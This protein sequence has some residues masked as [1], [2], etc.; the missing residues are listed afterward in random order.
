MSGMARARMIHRLQN[1]D[2]LKAAQPQVRI[3]DPKHRRSG[4]GRASTSR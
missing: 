4:C 3:H 2:G 1:D